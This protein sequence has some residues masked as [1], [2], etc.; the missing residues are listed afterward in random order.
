VEV[1]YVR[2]REKYGRSEK[3]GFMGKHVQHNME[4]PT[5]YRPPYLAAVQGEGRQQYYCKSY[6]TMS[7]IVRVERVL[8]H[9]NV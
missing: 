3:L 5:E 9:R 2:D 6:Q 7:K 4:Q 8:E 1:L